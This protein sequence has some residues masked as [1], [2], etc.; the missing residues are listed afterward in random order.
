MRHSC[1]I[2]II[3]YNSEKHSVSL[4]RQLDALIDE[5]IEVILIDNASSNFNVSVFKEVCSQVKI[6]ALEKNLGFAAANNIASKETEAD[7]LLF[8]NDDIVL[9][10]NPIPALIESYG[11]L[12][13]TGAL[14][15]I[16]KSIPGDT[17]H[18]PIQYAGSTK[19]NRFTGRN[20]IIETLPSNTTDLYYT[21]N[22]HGAAVLI[23]RELFIRLGGFSEDYFLYYEE[24]DLSEKINKSKMHVV[25]DP[26]IAVL[27]HGS[28]T[29]GHRSLTQSYY[30]NRGRIIF[31]RKWG[32]PLFFLYMIPWVASG[33]IRQTIQGGFKASA[34]FMR[35]IISG[36][37]ASTS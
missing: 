23:K 13:D 1:C 32:S 19:V 30:L 35:A 3:N 7:F 9:L 11:K 36:L 16:I 28:A 6:I 2:I 31:M 12:D 29:I 21:H 27:H 20:T 25:V 8:L 24:V 33:L 10:D 18:P 22:M 26:N 37:T 4:L 5:S 15:P 14:C 34:N 17:T